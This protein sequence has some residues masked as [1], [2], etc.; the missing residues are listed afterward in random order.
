MVFTDFS[1]EPA[2]LICMVEMSRFGI[3]DVRV[4]WVNG[5][6]GKINNNKKENNMS[7]KVLMGTPSLW[8]TGVAVQRLL[9]VKIMLIWDLI[10]AFTGF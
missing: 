3:K 8:T 2:D 9:K 10:F 5:W 6:T 4:R 7:R 1:H